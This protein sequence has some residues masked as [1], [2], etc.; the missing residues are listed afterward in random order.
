MA[1]T[2]FVLEQERRSAGFK[3]LNPLHDSHS[4]PISS[5]NKRRSMMVQVIH[6]MP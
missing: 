3:Y 1:I 4:R 2:D 5:L 6:N